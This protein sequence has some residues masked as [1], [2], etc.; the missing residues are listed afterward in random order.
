MPSSP[1][2][3]ADLELKLQRTE[4]AWAQCA[5]KVDSIIDCQSDYTG[6]SL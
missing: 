5:A 6:Q 2:N 1:L 4:G 3:N